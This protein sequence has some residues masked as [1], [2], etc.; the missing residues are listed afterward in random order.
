MKCERALRKIVGVYLE[1]KRHIL[2]Q[3]LLPRRVDMAHSKQTDIDKRVVLFAEY[4]LRENTTVRAVAKRFGFSKSTV[5]KDLTFR[6]KEIDPCL[7]RQVATLFERN[8]RERHI[9]GGNAT[10]LKYTELKKHG[11]R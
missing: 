2:Y 9:R 11:R 4:I 3:L 8:L 6:L 5:H 10:K 1:A 7:Y